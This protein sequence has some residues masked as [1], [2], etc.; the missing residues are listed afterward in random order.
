MA[1]L[2]R[3]QVD[4]ELDQLLRRAIEERYL[5]RF[6][7][8]GKERIVEPHDYGIQK[9]IDRLLCWQVGGQSGNPIPGWRLIDVADMQN[10]EILDRQFGGGRE[11][12]GK[13][14]RWE[15]VFI[16]V[17]PSKKGMSL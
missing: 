7:Y 2:D 16:R 17:T 4:R 6:R 11:V 8:K 1:K 12:P 5:I 15:K 14:H 9:G 13:H 10:C 3:T